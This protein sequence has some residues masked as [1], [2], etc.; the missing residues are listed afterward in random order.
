MW[1]LCPFCI[2]VPVRVRP[3]RLRAAGTYLRADLLA[4]ASGPVLAELDPESLTGAHL[5]SR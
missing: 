3:V 5:S 4:A 2:G 1:W